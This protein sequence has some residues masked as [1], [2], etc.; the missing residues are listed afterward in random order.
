M[1]GYVRFVEDEAGSVSVDWLA[2]ATGTLLLG[3]VAVHELYGTGA[4]SLQETLA[5]LAEN[6]DDKAGTR[7]AID[8]EPEELGFWDQLKV[9]G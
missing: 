1:C 7:D 3:A 5:Q 9:D 2:L 4:G 6:V 8:E